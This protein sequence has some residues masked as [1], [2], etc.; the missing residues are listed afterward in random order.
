MSRIDLSIAKYGDW[1]TEAT[2]VAQRL[3]NEASNKGVYNNDI[4]VMDGKFGDLTYAAVRNFQKTSRTLLV[5][6]VVGPLT[7]AKLGLIKGVD[8]AVPLRGQPTRT[9]CWS[10]CTKMLN[11]GFAPPTVL[12]NKTAAGGLV[13]TTDNLKNYAADLNWRF[14]EGPLSEQQFANI[15]ARVPMWVGG[16]VKGHE[17]GAKMHAIVYGGVFRYNFSGIEHLVRI[18]DPWPIGQGRIYFAKLSKVVQP[19]LQGA[20]DF[21][22]HWFL[23][24]PLF[25]P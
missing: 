14:H 6:G 21:N 10:T 12:A 7:F 9:T 25:V 5:D 19:K 3:L 1:E 17:S 22:P 8:Y 11:H 24:P 18:F 20:G 15:M 16:E 4:L 13:D 2:L 23:E